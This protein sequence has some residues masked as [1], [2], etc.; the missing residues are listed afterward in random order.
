MRKRLA[1]S[2]LVALA[3]VASAFAHQTFEPILLRRLIPETIQTVESVRGVQAGW[4]SPNCRPGT[5]WVCT[6]RGCW[7]N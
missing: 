3:L 4:T 6:N 5:S 1:P 7:C 2:G